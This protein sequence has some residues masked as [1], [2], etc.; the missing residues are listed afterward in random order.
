MKK[1]IKLGRQFRNGAGEAA[2]VGEDRRV[3]MSFS[4]EDPYERFFGM[5]VLGHK[6]D[7]MR[8]GRL[9]N[10]APLLAEHDPGQQIGVI[11]GWHVENGRGFV[12]VRFSRNQQGTDY[13][14]DVIDGIRTHVSVGYIVHEM[15]KTGEPDRAGG[16]ETFRCVDWEPLEVSF[17]SIAAD[18]GVGVGRSDSEDTKWV[19]E[20]S[21]DDG[22]PEPK[23]VI[24]MSE[25]QTVETVR[26]NG[27]AEAQ[28]QKDIRDCAGMIKDMPEINE[29]ARQFQDNGKSVG[30]FMD[31][32]RDL[33][34][35]A[36]PVTASPDI[37]MTE[38]ERDSFS[39]VRAA[40]AC[41][42]ND[43]SKAGLER[44]AS[45]AVANK[46]G[47]EARGFFLPDDIFQTRVI[48]TSG[49]G[50]ELVAT[51]HLAGAFID[52][53]RNRSVLLE[54]GA[55]TMGGLVG[56]VDIPKLS[57]GSTVSWINNESVDVS[58]NTPV[59]ASVNLSPKTIAA[60]V[61]FTRKMQLQSSPAVEGVIRNDLASALASGIDLAG[62]HGAG[63]NEPVG[64]AKI[65]ADAIVVPTGVG[66]VVGGTNGLAPT[67]AH[68][69]ELW[70]DTAVANAAGGS[71]VYITNPQVVAK[72]MQ[73]PVIAST[74]SRMIMPTADSFNGFRV[75][76][77]NQVTSTV[78]KGTSTDV[79]SAIL[80]GDFSQMII[81]MWGSLDIVP[82]NVTSADRGGLILRAFQDVDIVARHY[83]AFSVM[84][85]ALTA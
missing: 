16:V 45:N 3:T 17:V 51:D 79:C 58:A 66:D 72:L 40:L 38:K 81:G 6:P 4:S 53:L 68:M 71:Q 28:R 33:R 74:D 26:D 57:T 7:E 34:G 24:E 48:A 62:I 59:L 1:T 73:T 44:E 52:L 35:V 37:G 49:T 77:T 55:Q 2:T 21:Y 18:D 84:G 50:D 69:L 70:S 80:F 82:D 63:T 30:E 20:L 75:L 43:W 61:D 67:F 27:P 85:D 22:E 83:E 32:A 65:A 39:I 14:N 25:K 56:D 12:D 54:A 19:R 23:E 78:D 13:M 60:R 47:R 29:L 5:E 64:I 42:N 76:S 15:E 41:K 36:K 10:K 8:M 11:E 31:A 46:T 9:S